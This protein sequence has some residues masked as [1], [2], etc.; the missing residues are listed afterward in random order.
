MKSIFAFLFFFFLTL[1][2]LLMNGY[3]FGWWYNRCIHTYYLSGIF[4]RI[5]PTLYKKDMFVNEMKKQI[6]NLS[7]FWEII[8]KL[9]KFF[10]IE[11]IFFF[12]YISFLFITIISIFFLSIVLFKNKWIA[13]CSTLLYCLGLRQWSLGAPAIYLNIIHSTSLPI[14]VSIFIII[15]FLK[16]HYYWCFLLIGIL[17]GNYVTSITKIKYT[18]DRYT[19][20][21]QDNFDHGIRFKRGKVYINGIEGF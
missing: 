14:F 11:N 7:F 20:V 4:A 5:D 17:F 18:G 16:K 15:L 21:K 6:I 10:N 12:L 8:G 13:L 9:I 19:R 3:R 1:H 2:S